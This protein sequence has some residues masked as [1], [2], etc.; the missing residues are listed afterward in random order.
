MKQWLL[1]AC[2][3]TMY[4]GLAS[5]VVLIFGAIGDPASQPTRWPAM[6]AVMLVTL[7]VKQVAGR[8]TERNTSTIVA[9]I[10]LAT[11]AL[12]LKS[13]IGGGLSPL[14]GWGVFVP[15]EVP[16]F[17]ELLFS[18]TA[19]L[20][21]VGRALILDSYGAH[22]VASLFRRSLIFMLALLPVPVILFDVTYANTALLNALASHIII[23]MS[24]A[25]LALMVSNS[26]GHENA[27][28][29]RWLVSGGLPVVGLIGGSLLVSAL[30]STSLRALLFQALGAILGVLATLFGAIA[31]V[32]SAMVRWFIGLFDRSQPPPSELVPSSNT[33][34]DDLN[35]LVNEL[36]QS[37][38][39]PPSPLFELIS[40]TITLVVLLL[41]LWLAV[42]WGLNFWRKHQQA[43]SS[44]DER[45]S[46]WS[47]G[48]VGQDLQSLWRGWV[49][50]L[51]RRSAAD[52][53]RGDTPAL[54]IRRAYRR[55]LELGVEA[56]KARSVDQT[57]R[58]YGGEATSFVPAATTS[59]GQLTSAYEAARYAEGAS[60]AE[61]AAAEAALAEIEAQTRSAPGR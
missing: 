61:A 3:I 12:M 16:I 31:L 26:S 53:L 13:L 4:V 5:I 20:L 60:A 7:L 2:L 18:T 23:F 22:E 48:Q 59:I 11:V 30:F 57:A 52:E 19:L 49:D 43:R 8:L 35:R 25:L 47:W 17:Q 28:G 1:P 45:T 36:N 34:E 55:L 38:A 58:E 6:A 9:A 39:A 50:S 54:R 14:S 29:Q 44:V 10:S 15:Q 33:V 32:V 27:S 41:L 40:R 46:L 42:R 51:G 56:E 24:S 21:L 37:Q